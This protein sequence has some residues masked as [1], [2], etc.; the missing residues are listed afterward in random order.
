MFAFSLIDET[1]KLFCNIYDKAAQELIGLDAT[2]FT[3]LS[4]ESK[5]EIIK[6]IYSEENRYLVG[7]RI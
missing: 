4:L 5:D 7:G 6:E 1:G 3:R 2:E